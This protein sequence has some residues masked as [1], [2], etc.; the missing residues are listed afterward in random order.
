MNLAKGFAIVATFSVASSAF[1]DE[2][3]P[4]TVGRQVIARADT[5]AAQ[6]GRTATLDEYAGCYETADGMAFVVVREE[7]GLTIDLPEGWAF[8]E[9]RLRADGSEGL[10]VAELAVAVTFEVDADGS[11]QSVTVYP[12]NGQAAIEAAK[13]PSRRGIVT[14]HDIADSTP[15]GVTIASVN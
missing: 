5:N 9:S 8:R 3:I 1:A 14:I 11:V 6:T 4:S 10:F 12:P 2:S 13:T 7:D 15:K